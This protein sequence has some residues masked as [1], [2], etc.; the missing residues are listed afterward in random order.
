MSYLF[1][2]LNQIP[3]CA[4]LFCTLHSCTNGRTHKLIIFTRLRIM[5][6]FV[7]QDPDMP[8]FIH[9][10]ID[11]TIDM[12]TPDVMEEVSRKTNEILLYYRSFSRLQRFSSPNRWHQGLPTSFKNSNSRNIQNQAMNQ[13]MPVN[14]SRTTVVG[15]DNHLIKNEQLQRHQT[16]PGSIH[17]LHRVKRAYSKENSQLIKRMV[18]FHGNHKDQKQSLI[19]VSSKNLDSAS[20]NELGT[21]SPA[22]ESMTST[23]ASSQDPSG[24]FQV[25]NCKSHNNHL[26]IASTPVK[27]RLFREKKYHLIQTII[28]K[29][30]H[31]CTRYCH[32]CC[33]VCTLAQFTKVKYVSRNLCALWSS[34]QTRCWLC[35]RRLAR[36]Q[37]QVRTNL[38]V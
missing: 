2:R 32:Y 22:R 34:T 20:F 31:L 15:D 21:S 38:F 1:S 30:V 25:H 37:V 6:V 12:I 26:L 10:A 19:A 28:N 18:Q 4:H 5:I 3:A 17:P 27:R 13:I 11:E 24:N 29:P 23:S 16:S 14:E 7:L 35:N 8:D 33:T 36:L 9:D